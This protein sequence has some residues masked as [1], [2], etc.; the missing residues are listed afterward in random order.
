MTTTPRRVLVVEDDPAIRRGI[1]AAL[2]FA[3]YEVLEAADGPRGLALA[4][5]AEVDLVLLDVVLPGTDGLEILRRVRESRPT[6]PVILLTARAAEDDRVGGL[7]AGADDYV[8][9]P[10]SVRELLA[11]VE[12]VLRRSPERPRPVELIECHGLVVDLARREIR[13]ADGDRVELSEKE[14]EL[15]AYLAA[16][17]GRAISREELL[18]RVWRLD[19]RGVTTRTIDMHVMRLREKLRDDTTAPRRVLTVRGQG[20]AWA[21]AEAGR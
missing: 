3:G 14:A 20:Y 18:R 2:A 19:P 13:H 4:E 12:A 5:A 11:R 21:A 6:R 17:A 10:F 1:V 16:H 15:A 7:A 9:K 8:V